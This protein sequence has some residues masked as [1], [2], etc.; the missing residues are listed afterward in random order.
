LL[1][2][3]QTGIDEMAPQ[4]RHKKHHSALKHGGYSALGLLP[5]E[6]PTEFEQLHKRVIEEF[7]PSAGEPQSEP[8]NDHG[9]AK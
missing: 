6:S 8:G 1:R 7:A 9:A 3:S 4:V 2:E 5:G